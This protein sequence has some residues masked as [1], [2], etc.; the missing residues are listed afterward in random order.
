[1]TRVLIVGG[2]FAGMNAAKVLGGASGVDV[3]LIDKRNHHLFQPLLYQVAMAGLSP[4]DI[5]MPIR[6]MLSRFENIRVLLGTVEALDLNRSVARTDI[7]EIP[8]DYLIVGCGATHSYFGH[9]QWEEFAPGLKTL[10]QATEIRRR[11]LTAFE[12]AERISDPEQQNRLLTFAIVGGGPT[13]VELAGA[14]AEMS[15][16]TLA[17]DF[18]NISARSA[19]VVLLE[20]GPR[21]L[22]TFSDDQAARAVRD[23]GEMGV[24]VS[25][26][27]AVT[28]IDGDGVQI[29]AE[30]LC[31]GTVLWAAGVRAA[32][33]GASTSVDVDPQG[34]VI[35]EPD[36]TLKGHSHVFVTGDQARFTHQTGKPLP[37]TA[38]VAMQAGRYAAH[39]ILGD[40]RG[41]ARTPFHFVDKGQMAT[42]GR[43][44][45][46]LEIGSLKLGGWPAWVLWL[47]IH[48]YYL[49]GFKNRLLVVVQ[50]AW[51]YVTFGRGARLITGQDWRM[52][53]A[54]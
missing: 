47:V 28:N 22:P 54:R 9:D 27:S 12:L 21:I 40:L 25:T 26:G 29:G 13:G 5:A 35:V 32:Q 23:L 46:I 16:F 7:G 38:P 14:I 19:R 15:R 20:A 42:I 8:F 48:I 30:R 10:E 45:A 41:R 3:T 44:R 37:G 11:V 17:K 34:R 36:L 31:A 51:S 33:L 53:K 1:M 50:W 18:R 2:G 24:R 43:S 39:T 52:G 49:T 6:S 4:A